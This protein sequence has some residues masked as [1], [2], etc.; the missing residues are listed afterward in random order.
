MSFEQRFQPAAPEPDDDIELEINLIPPIVQDFDPVSVINQDIRPSSD[1][2]KDTQDSTIKSEN[3]GEQPDLQTQPQIIDL[4]PGEYRLINPED[5][6]VS[7]VEVKVADKP[8]K[9]S[10]S[11]F[12]PA[13]SVLQPFDPLNVP[14][15]ISPDKP[16][17]VAGYPEKTLP[18]HSQVLSRFGDVNGIDYQKAGQLSKQLGQRWPDQVHELGVTPDGQIIGLVT[19]KKGSAVG[20]VG[21]DQNLRYKPEPVQVDFDWDRLITSSPRAYIEQQVENV[22]ASFLKLHPLCQAAAKLK[23]LGAVDFQPF[24]PDQAIRK[25][26]KAN[27]YPQLFHGCA[28]LRQIKPEDACYYQSS[29]DP[30]LVV[31][32]IQGQTTIDQYPDAPGLTREQLRQQRKSLQVERIYF[33]PPVLFTRRG[34]VNAQTAKASGPYSHI[35]LKIAKELYGP[36]PSILGISRTRKPHDLRRVVTTVNRLLD[37][38]SLTSGRQ[39]IEAGVDASTFYAMN[40]SVIAAAVN[41]MMVNL[42]QEANKTYRRHY[43]LD[44]QLQETLFG[45]AMAADYE[46]KRK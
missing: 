44:Q 18:E 13:E 25:H 7:A 32:D 35:L 23:A 3:M 2:E 27:I 38:D 46:A 1:F 8:E 22:L 42:T 34:E 28:D 39:M 31:V 10:G 4:Q 33:D 14:W 30:D 6:L 24:E 45:L 29:F 12:R 19:C 17:T 36:Q 40:V 15:V 11:G 9:D 41:Y 26:V 16:A 20:F 5:R 43:E 37:P 21:Q